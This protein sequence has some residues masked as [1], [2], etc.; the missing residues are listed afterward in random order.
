MDDTAKVLCL[1]CVQEKLYCK[2]GVWARGAHALARLPA[3]R[4]TFQ[5][6]NFSVR[7]KLRALH[8]RRFISF[9]SCSILIYES[10]NRL[11]K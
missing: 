7:Q 8:S 5:P 6:I 4:R 10:L 9:S 11:Y 3:G 2:I 1:R